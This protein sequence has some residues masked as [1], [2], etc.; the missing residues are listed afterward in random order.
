[1]IHGGLDGTSK[2]AL[3]ESSAGRRADVALT[4]AISGLRFCG[5]SEP[6]VALLPAG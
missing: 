5:K 6:A 4:M 3:R 1:M 2:R